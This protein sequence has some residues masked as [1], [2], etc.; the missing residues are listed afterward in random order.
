MN[1]TGKQHFRSSQ[2]W[3]WFMDE[4]MSCPHLSE[5]QATLEMSQVEQD[6]RGFPKSPS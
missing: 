4:H 2:V 5:H 1:E 6:S 3:T